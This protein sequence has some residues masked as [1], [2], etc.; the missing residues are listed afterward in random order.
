M[1]VELGSAICDADVSSRAVRAD[2]AVNRHANRGLRAHA[3]PFA[4][5]IVRAARGIRAA[6]SPER[7]ST[8]PA[9]R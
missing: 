3:K 2:L 7:P 9:C 5:A 4:P 8:P 1:T 6:G